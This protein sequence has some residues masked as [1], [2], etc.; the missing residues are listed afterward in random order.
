MSGYALR[1]I[2]T[3]K[4]AN[5]VDVLLVKYDNGQ[6][7]PIS[8]SVTVDCFLTGCELEVWTEGGLL[9]AHV[10]GPM[11][12]PELASDPNVK[13][14]ADFSAPIVENGFGGLGL[15]HTSTVGTESRILVHSVLAGWK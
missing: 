1:V 4:Y 7:S 3:T 5:A 6:I 12:R 9:K 15:Q 10:E 14:S 8:E 2:R 13:R 11:G